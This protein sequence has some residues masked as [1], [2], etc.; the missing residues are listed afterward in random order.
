MGFAVRRRRTDL[1]QG[2]IG[3]FSKVL[4]KQ[5]AALATLAELEE[6][7][8]LRANLAKKRAKRIADLKLSGEYDGLLQEAKDQVLQTRQAT[9]LWRIRNGVITTREG[10]F[11]DD[12]KSDAE[13]GAWQVVADA[14]QDLNEHF[15]P[16][17]RVFS[18]PDKPQHDATGRTMYFGV[19]PTQNL[20]HQRDGKTRFDDSATYEVRCFVRRHNAC[21]SKGAKLPDCK[22]ELVW[23]DATEPYRLAAP[24][25]LEGT[26][27]RPVTIQMPDLKELAA[28]AM[29]RPRGQ[30]S[31][32]KFKQPQHLMPQ[33][34]GNAVAGGKM[35]GEA[36]CFFSIPLI[37]IIALFVLNLFLPIVVFLFNLWFLLAFRFCIPPSLSVD[38]D[39]SAS[40][41]VVPPS[42]DLDV[43]AAV[44]IGGDVKTPDELHDLLKAGVQAALASENGGVSI[45]PDAASALDNLSN[46]SM[47]AMMLNAADAANMPDEDVLAAEKDVSVP[48]VDYGA[49]T[50]YD[51]VTSQWKPVEGRA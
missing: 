21:C 23:S 18:D 49:Q 11:S 32:V 1:P 2:K 10:W 46:E 19:I 34:S 30:L 31:P 47:T 45:D 28:Q 27:N 6:C 42:I 13:I 39:L 36:I 50:Y 41:D 48:G 33:V 44:N 17:Y 20:Q 14:P 25:D 35:G 12:G 24:F 37:T 3:E 26:S 40:L 4:S 5:N 15:F 22:G 9:V 16:L 38:L 8:P 43:Q 51:L 7:S 29:A